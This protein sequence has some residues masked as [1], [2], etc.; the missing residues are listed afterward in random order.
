MDKLKDLL[1]QFGVIYGARL[2]KKE[3]EI[4]IDQ[5]KDL[6]MANNYKLEL[7][8]YHGSLH[9]H[10]NVSK[11]SK[12]ILLVP[13]DTPSTSYY[14]DDYYT[15]NSADYKSFRSKKNIR[16]KMFQE[17]IQT[18]LIAL[19]AYFS[20]NSNQIIKIIGLILVVLQIIYLVLSLREKS[21]KVN[22]NFNSSALALAL[23]MAA[24]PEIGIILIDDFYKNIN[25]T[26]YLVDKKIDKQANS[27]LLESLSGAGELIISK[28][29][30]SSQLKFD[31]DLNYIEKNDFYTCLNVGEVYEGNVRV[32][33]NSVFDDSHVSVDK[34]RDYELVINK[35]IGAIKW[36]CYFN[37]MIL[38]LPKR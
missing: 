22:M 16:I 23:T 28:G 14:K 9:A 1:T 3:K 19:V 15:L 38:E 10:I 2:S 5:I 11:H 31:N 32:K 20:L 27:I 26:S 36:D 12:A 24:N 29:L 37:Q 8:D 25:W 35:M 18:M 4:F 21:L 33:I 7:N 17:I 6:S 34:L 30:K 13:Y